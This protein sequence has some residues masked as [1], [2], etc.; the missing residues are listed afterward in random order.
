[1]RTWLSRAVLHYGN[2]LQTLGVVRPNL[3]RVGKE[4]AVDLVDDLQMARNHALEQPHRPSLERLRHQSVIS[5][6]DGGAGNLPGN[7]P[8]KIIFVDE[9]AHQFC[10]SQ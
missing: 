4:P 2:A 10:N 8:G 6:S 7:G 9:R 1:M 5:I 3:R